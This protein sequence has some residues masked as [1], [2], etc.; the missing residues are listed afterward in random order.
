MAKGV[1]KIKFAEGDAFSNGSIPNVKL[2]I[3]PNKYVYFKVSEWEKDTTEADK[4]KDLTWMR[5]EHDR[6]TILN[7]MTLKASEMYGFKISK[8]LCGPYT[9]YIEASLNGKTSADNTGLYVGGRCDHKIVK[10]GFRH[11]KKHDFLAC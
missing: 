9:Y 11:M 1:K 7:Q 5:L 8:N 3:P 10:T 4:K 2:V 6:K